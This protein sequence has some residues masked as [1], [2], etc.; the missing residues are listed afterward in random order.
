LQLCQV[1]EAARRAANLRRAGRRQVPGKLAKGW[2]YQEV[3]QPTCH[4]C[5]EPDVAGKMHATTFEQVLDNVKNVELDIW[6][7]YRS[8]I[9]GYAV[10]GEWFVRHWT[11]PGNKN[12]CTNNGNLGACL[13][14][15]KKWADAHKDG[16]YPIT[17]FLDKKEAWSSVQ[18]GRRPADLDKLVETSLGGALYKPA[19]LQGTYASLRE[20]AKAGAWPTLGDLAGKVIVVL[21]GNG[22]NEYLT[23]RGSAAAA[24]VA[25]DTSSDGDVDGTPSAFTAATAA[26]LVFYNIEA[27]G[28]RDRLGLKTRANQYVSRLWGGDS[29]D[30]CKVFSNC[31]ND[32]ALY[33]WN[34]G[35]CNTVS[36]GVLKPTSAAASKP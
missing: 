36:M 32:M 13:T 4:N 7:N 34:T 26:Y 23:D 3:F 28:S 5:Y 29:W 18:E 15:I 25:P 12:V 19:A 17:L 21:T 11:G 31:I 10:P 1:S 16:P 20:A 27:T 9:T 30:P 22:L 14:D 8:W 2:H 33:R 35:V 6:D 24:F